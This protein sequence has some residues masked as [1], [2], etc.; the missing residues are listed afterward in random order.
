MPLWSVR[1]LLLGLV[2]AC[3]IPGVIGVGFLIM[4]MYQDGRLRI[5]NNTIQTAR[6]LVQAVDGE[7]DKT[8]V[9]AVA[10]ATSSR[11]GRFPSPRS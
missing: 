9:V 5:E 10:L 4:R 8:K 3:L 7:L 11:P 1:T 2:L 6:A